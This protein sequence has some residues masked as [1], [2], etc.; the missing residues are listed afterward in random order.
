M[1]KRSNTK[2]NTGNMTK[3]ETNIIG[4]T[5][6][7]MISRMTIGGMIR[8]ATISGMTIGGMIREA[9]ISGMTIGGM[10]REATISGMT[11]EVMISR[12]ISDV[13]DIDIA[14]LAVATTDAFFPN[15]ICAEC[16]NRL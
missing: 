16:Q 11:T 13:T 6:G 14:L 10:I 4:T 3:A 1:P 2:K 12:T 15:P 7:V 8:E 5:T 9:T